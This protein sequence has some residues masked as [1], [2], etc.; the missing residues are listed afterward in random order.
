VHAYTVLGPSLYVPL[1]RRGHVALGVG[2]EL[3]VAGTRP[4]DWR[5]GSF[6]LWEYNDG[7]FWAW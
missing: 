2:A 3:P 4:F 6:L 5:L 1:S 7:P